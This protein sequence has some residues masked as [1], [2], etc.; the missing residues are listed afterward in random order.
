MSYKKFAIEKK[1]FIFEA[2]KFFF[3]GKKPKILIKKKKKN[4]KFFLKGS[5]VAEKNQ[6]HSTRLLGEKKFLTKSKKMK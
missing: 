4:F 6:K 1:F 5:E 2:P 3:G